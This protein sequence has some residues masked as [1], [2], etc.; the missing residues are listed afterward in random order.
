VP[1]DPKIMSLLNGEW[2]LCMLVGHM[3]GEEKYKWVRLN[4]VVKYCR[5]GKGSVY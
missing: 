2:Y 1:Y 5:T 3:I 4:V